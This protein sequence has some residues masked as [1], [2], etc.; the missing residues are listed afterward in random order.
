MI[1][2]KRVY[3]MLQKLVENAQLMSIFMS[4]SQE[5][6]VVHCNAAINSCILCWLQAADLLG[7]WCSRGQR[8]DVIS[9]NTMTT[10]LEKGSLWQAAWKL[11]SQVGLLDFHLAVGLLEVPL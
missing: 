7:T 1:F 9:C 11:L 8:M 10:A 2:S 5:V 6:N 4:I 3:F